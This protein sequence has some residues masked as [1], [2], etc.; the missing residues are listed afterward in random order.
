MA[1]VRDRFRARARA[2]ARVSVRARVRARV[3]VEVELL[4]APVDVPLVGLDADGRHGGP[5]LLE[6]HLSRDGVRVRDWG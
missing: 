5:P 1:R 3:S 6:A 2:R 4:E